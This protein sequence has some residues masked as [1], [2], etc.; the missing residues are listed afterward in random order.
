MKTQPRLYRCYAERST[1]AALSQPLSHNRSLPAG[2]LNM[3]LAFTLRR[4]LQ[5]LAFRKGGFGTIAAEFAAPTLPL[6]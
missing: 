5:L 1:R 3:T 6:P 2:S 4:P